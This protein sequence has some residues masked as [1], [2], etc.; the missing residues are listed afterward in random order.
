MLRTNNVIIPLS[1]V[2]LCCTLNVLKD[3]KGGAATLNNVEEVFHNIDAVQQCCCCCCCSSKVSGE[4]DQGYSD[5]LGV[6][7]GGWGE[8]RGGGADGG[9]HQC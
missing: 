9:D 1:T 6:A 3:G 4:R 8:G 2:L 7:Q 5:S